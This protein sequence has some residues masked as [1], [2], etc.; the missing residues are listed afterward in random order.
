M[1][2]L[3]TTLEKVAEQSTLNEKVLDAV[4]KKTREQ[5]ERMKTE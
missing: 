2:T 4:R 1:I 5:E 3:K